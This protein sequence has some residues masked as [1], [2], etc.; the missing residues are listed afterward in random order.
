MNKFFVFIQN[1]QIH[2]PVVDNQPVYLIS[3]DLKL[4]NSKHDQSLIAFDCS[5][6]ISISLLPERRGQPFLITLNQSR[7]S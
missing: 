2:T 6:S 7:I 3:C 1:K 4:L 5:F